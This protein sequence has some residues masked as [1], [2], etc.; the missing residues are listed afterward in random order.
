MEK[1]NYQIEGMTIAITNMEAMLSFY[2]NVFNIQFTE[3]EI[4]GSK[5]YSGV[6]GGLN[7]L[8][9]PA[10][11]AGN[12]AEQNRHQ[13]DIIVSDLTKTIQLTIKYGGKTMGEIVEDEISG[14]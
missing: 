13:L 1:E 11:I 4:N 10:K 2:S 6:W 7:L 3:K 8:F 12:T 9:C 5:L 14:I